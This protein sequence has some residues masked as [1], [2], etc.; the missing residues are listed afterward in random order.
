MKTKTIQTIYSLWTEWDGIIGYYD[1]KETAL[2][3]AKVVFNN[4]S[5]E[6]P[7]ETLEDWLEQEIM[8][9]HDEYV[10]AED[11]SDAA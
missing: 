11:I 2:K 5:Q 10:E 6:D 3:I 9:I 7:S 4:N 1:T 8:S